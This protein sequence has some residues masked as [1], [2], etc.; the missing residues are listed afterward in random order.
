MFCVYIRDT[1]SDLWSYENS[2]DT[3]KEAVS[4]LWNKQEDETGQIIYSAL[5]PK[6]IKEIKRKRK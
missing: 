2:Y 1:P 4:Q 3:Y 5:P 6:T